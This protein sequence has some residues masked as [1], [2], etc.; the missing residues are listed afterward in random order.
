MSARRLIF[1]TG[2]RAEYEIMA[3]VIRAS[4]AA[5]LDSAVI[6]GA[7]HRSPLHG[8]GLALIRADGVA[9]AAE[10]D[11]LLPSDSW[12]SRAQSFSRFF[13]GVCR[14]LAGARPDLLVVA[15]DREEA[16]AGALA[17]NFLQIPVAHLFGGDRCLASDVDEVF[18]PAISKLAHL[19]LTATDG[20]RERLLRMGER[21]DCVWTIGATSLDRLADEPVMTRDALAEDLGDDVRLPYFVLLQHPAPMV[22]DVDTAAEMA[23]VL[24][25]VLAPGHAVFCGYPNFDPGNAAMRRVLDVAAVRT[26][27]LHVFS[28]LPRRQFVNLLRHCVAF[29]G[30][31]SSIV[32]ET[33]FLHIAGIL[34]GRR[35]ELREAGANVLRVPIDAASI[36]AACRK[37]HDDPD[38]RAVVARC[39]SPYGDGK[40]AARAAA[41]L[42]EVK[43]GRDLL[44]KTVTY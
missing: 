44:M 33:G 5:G 13:D 28:T 38:F 4:M 9:I 27:S 42:A 15:G 1:V 2:T 22:N 39:S 37:A 26:P 40:S 19:H 6:A 34:V 14:A 31:S 41:I 8:D 36:A 16:L 32:I 23:T 25:G 29:V 10:I 30:N 3:P 20:H 43:L 24:Q 21:P 7:G 11:S 17:G 12:E 35:Q 18:R